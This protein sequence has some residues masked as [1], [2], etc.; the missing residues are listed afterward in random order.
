MQGGSARRLSSAQLTLARLAAAQRG[1]QAPAASAML[2]PA[3]ALAE[4]AALL[5]RAPSSGRKSRARALAILQEEV[6]G[7]GGM[8]MG[9]EV[10]GEGGMS[11]GKSATQWDSSATGLSV[12]Q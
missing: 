6:E 12:G 2:P 9:M 8:G 3:P 4:P 1:W 7:R 5:P 11:V 10:I